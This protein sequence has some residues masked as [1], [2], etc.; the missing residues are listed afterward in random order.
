MSK[1]GMTAR[2]AEID[3]AIMLSALHS[4]KAVIESCEQHQQRETTS[5]SPS[6]PRRRKRVIQ[7]ARTPS[8]APYPGA[9]QGDGIFPA[10]RENTGKNPVGAR[11]RRNSSQIDPCNQVLISSFPMHRAGKRIPCQ[12]CWQGNGREKIR[13]WAGDRSGQQQNTAFPSDTYTSIWSFPV[14]PS[15]EF[16]AGNAHRQRMLR[17]RPLAPPQAAPIAAA[18]PAGALHHPGADH[19]PKSGRQDGGVSIA[20]KASARSLLRG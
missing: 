10:T 11:N 7:S 16:F 17:D 5:R 6:S 19:T 1:R 12:V 4:Q 14:V 18:R 3:A 15:R 13:I 8:A 20:E 2:L 9:A